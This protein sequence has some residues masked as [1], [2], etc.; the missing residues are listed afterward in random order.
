M[1]PLTPHRVRA[2]MAA[3]PSTGTTSN[4]A[5]TEPRVGIQAGNGEP[6]DNRAVKA[7]VMAKIGFE[8]VHASSRC[9]M[10]A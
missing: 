3:T 10:L 2:T 8:A 7:R 5:A 9:G 6:G 1:G 4:A